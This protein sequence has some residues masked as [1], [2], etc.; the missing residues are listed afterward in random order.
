MGGIDLVSRAYSEGTT[1]DCM[2]ASKSHGHRQTVSIDTS[3]HVQTLPLRHD[4]T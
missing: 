2:R 3:V 4:F 1:C